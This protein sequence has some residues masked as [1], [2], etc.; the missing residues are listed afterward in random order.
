MLIF[1]WLWLYLQTNLFVEICRKL[2]NNVV[3]WNP[4]WLQVHK[5]SAFVAW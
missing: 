5:A 4:Q 2:W 1:N 3:L